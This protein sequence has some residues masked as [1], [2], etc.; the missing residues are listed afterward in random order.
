[1]KIFQKPDYKLDTNYGFFYH[2]RDGLAA[3]LLQ[4]SIDFRLLLKENLQY[5]LLDA[6]YWYIL[7]S[8]LTLVK[9]EGDTCIPMADSC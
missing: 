2:N 6:S 5:V 9:D 8:P 7:P 4:Y 1:M 3:V